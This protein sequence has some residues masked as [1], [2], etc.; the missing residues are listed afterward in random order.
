MALTAI[1]IDFN[2]LDDTIEPKQIVLIDTSD[3]GEIENN[4]AV[5]EI[6]PPGYKTPVVNPFMKNEVTVVTAKSLGL[7]KETCRY[8]VDLPDGVYQ[9]TVKGSPDTFYREKFFLKT[10]QL[11]LEFD[12]LLVSMLDGCNN[13]SAANQEMFVKI[14]FMLLAARAHI[15]LGNWCKAHEIYLEAEKLLKNMNCHGVLRK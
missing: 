15:R 12:K 5:I 1:N 3:W 9:I 14:Y 10:D 8:D 2:I 13:M 11:R 7:Q 4:P 6:V